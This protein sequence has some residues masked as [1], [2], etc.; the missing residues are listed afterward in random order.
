MVVIYIFLILIIFLRIKTYNESSLPIIQYFVF[1]K[2]VKRIDASKSPD[3]V[4]LFF[5]YIDLFKYKFISIYKLRFT[6]KLKLVL[7]NLSRLIFLFK[8]YI[9]II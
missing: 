8:K 5:Y 9:L 2:M 1:L 6:K 3:E 7:I 4:V